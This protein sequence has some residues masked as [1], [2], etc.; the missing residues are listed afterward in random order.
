MRRNVG[1]PRMDCCA[2]RCGPASATTE[3]AAHRQAPTDGNWRKEWRKA[4]K[5][6]GCPDAL[7]HD[8]RRTVVRNLI[9]AGTPERVAM[10]WTGHKTR[11]I[12]D[13]YHIIRE[14]D[15][16]E[17]GAQLAHYLTSSKGMDSRKA[18]VCADT[19]LLTF[20]SLPLAAT[21]SAS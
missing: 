20:I 12:S 1:P 17:A 10:S 15:L 21:G 18:D 13:R 5:A 8:L 11:S 19:E 4:K 6:A 2:L 3:P 14:S 16:K 7:L 9:R